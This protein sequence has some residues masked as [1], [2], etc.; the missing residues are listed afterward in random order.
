MT[1]IRRQTFAVGDTIRRSHVEA[2]EGMTDT[3]AKLRAALRHMVDD[4]DRNQRP[5]GGSS[6]PDWVRAALGDNQ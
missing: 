2:V 6:V 1:N 4:A 3:I 5:G